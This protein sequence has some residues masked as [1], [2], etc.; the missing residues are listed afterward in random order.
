MGAY[1]FA[2]GVDERGFGGLKD[3]LRSGGGLLAGVDLDAFAGDGEDG[4]LRGR[5]VSV[6]FCAIAAVARKR[7]AT[8]IESEMDSLRHR[9]SLRRGSVSRVWRNETE[10]GGCGGWEDTGMTMTSAVKTNDGAMV[11]PSYFPGKQW[12]QVLERD[13]RADGQFVYAVKSTKIYCKPSCASRRPTRKQVSFFPTPAQAEAA[14]Y[15]ACKRCEP[16]RT[17]AKAD[18]QAGAIAAVTEYLRE[19]ADRSGRGWPMWRRRPAWGG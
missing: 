14:G 2:G 10:C 19:H 17:E 13:A 4:V 11:V 18:P 12:Q 1:G 15:R 16:E 6:G 5:A 3:P 7:V 8:R 9:N